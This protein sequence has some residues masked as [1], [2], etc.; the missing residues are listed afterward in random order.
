MLTDK[1]KKEFIKLKKKLLEMEFSRLNGPQRE[2][3]FKINGPLLVLAGAGS[4]KTSVLVNRIAYMIKY[5][6]AYHSDDVPDG[7]T[8]D[9]LAVRDTVYAPEI[10]PYIEGVD[11]LYHEATFAESEL[12][13]AA[14]T[15]H[16]TARQAA[17]IAAAAGVKKLMIGHFSSRYNELDT[18]LNEAR[19]VFSDTELA[20]EGKI[21]SL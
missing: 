11:L 16:S 2:A 17:V 3:V 13:R 14:E 5:G 15:Y 19:A 12:N 7:L 9:D 8:D 6:N 10:I 18:L 1:G 20:D 21:V 4:G